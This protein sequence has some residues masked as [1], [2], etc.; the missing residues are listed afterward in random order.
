MK[1]ITIILLVI[2]SF[3]SCNTTKDEKPD[4]ESSIS[5]SDTI[6]DK[7]KWRVKDGSDYPY[8]DQML[9]DIV[10]NDTVRSLNENEIIEL[11]GEPDRINEGFLYY[12]IS[13]KR[14]GF[15][16]LHTRTLV[17]KISED[18]SIEW[19]KIHE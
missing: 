6:F 1:Y 5:E 19:I 18:T 15:W 9:H 2:L 11:L 10:Y 17:I 8:R 13:Q 14:I 4:K 3:T 7:T 12:M 16:P